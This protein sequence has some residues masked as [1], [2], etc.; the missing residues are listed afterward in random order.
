MN[1][2]IS[3]TQRVVLSRLDDSHLIIKKEWRRGKD[4]EWRPCKG[5][6][7]P[8][9]ASFELSTWFGNVATAEN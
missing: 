8:I 5:I 3:D 9:E 2:K 1:I 4:D 7:L 6:R